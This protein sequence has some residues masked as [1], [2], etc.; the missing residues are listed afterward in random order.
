[1]SEATTRSGLLKSIGPGLLWA[2]AA[3]GVSHLVQSTRAGAS[4]GFS[5]VWIVLLA[6]IFKYPFF[7]Y[8][9]RY[10][11]AKGESLLD[12]YVRLGRVYLWIYIG[13]TLLTMFTIQSAVT[14]VTAGLASQL[15]GITSSA[16][17]WSA[18]LLLICAVIL[19]IGKYPLLDKAIKLIIIL[20]TLST[21]TAV[22]IALGRGSHVQPGFMHPSPWTP[23]GFTFIIALMG[24][25][26]S[27]IDISVWHSLWTLERKKQTGHSPSLRESLFDFNIGYGGA[28]VL[29]VAFLTLGAMVMYGTGQ[30]FEQGAAG[31]A[32]QII[33]LY[34]SSLG[35][36]SRIIIGI[37]A[38]TTMFSTTLTCLDAFPRVLQKSTQ[39]VFK[40][41]K[42]HASGANRYYWIWML[43]VGTGTVL[44]LN[45]WIRGLKEMVDIAT[46]LSFLTAPVLGYINFRVVTATFM[47]DKA[48]PG[49]GMRL[50]SY[51]G[52]VFLTLFGVIFLILLARS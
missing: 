20:L 47:P 23:V 36:W 12:G 3:I 33:R 49:R 27:A 22:L 4:Y 5:L 40:L 50:L 8:G 31:F 48:R 42:S 38:F 35:D 41:P 30:T 6:N 25:M 18:I 39:L 2:G 14:I 11:A 34:T 17:L 37:A 9:P 29:S 24:W 45:L 51:T 10:A 13:F 43:V 26:P 1:M 44:I 7:E 52:L 16:G 46:I 21:I 15:F 19:A 28:I 32:E